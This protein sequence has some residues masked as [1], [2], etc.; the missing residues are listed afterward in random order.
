MMSRNDSMKAQQRSLEKAPTDQS[1]I[2]WANMAFF[3]TLIESSRF[4]DE[5][6]LSSVEW[7]QRDI[8]NDPILLQH[9]QGSQPV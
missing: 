1:Q 8:F 4:Y 6:M 2:H 3:Y 9:V 7:R 5:V